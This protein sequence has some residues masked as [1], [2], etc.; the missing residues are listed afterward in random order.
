MRNYLYIIVLFLFSCKDQKPDDIMLFNGV[1][2][3]TK[4]G[5]TLPN[6][7]QNINN[8]Y[9][10]YLKN[11]QNSIPLFK[12]IHHEKYGIFIGLPYGISGDSLLNIKPS[13]PL[14]NQQKQSVDSNTMTYRSYYTQQGLQLHTLACQVNK[15]KILIIGRTYTN[16][17]P[18]SLL[19]EKA[20]RERIK[21]TTNP[22]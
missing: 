17:L 20:L 2:F 13:I 15:S 5:E 10:K 16:N 8:E 6:I 4:T 1:S 12:Y 22:Q 14:L 3:L 7:D 21:I 11:N 19:S 9:N 18:D